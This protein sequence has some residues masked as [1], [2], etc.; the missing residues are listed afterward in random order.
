MVLSQRLHSSLILYIT[1][2]NSDS[3]ATRYHTIKLG[4]KA[5]AEKNQTFFRAAKYMRQSYI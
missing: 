2:L 4:S 5:P 1:F 3:Y